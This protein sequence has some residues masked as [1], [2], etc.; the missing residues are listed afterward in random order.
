[1]TIIIIISAMSMQLYKKVYNLLIILLQQQSNNYDCWANKQ[2]KTKQN[3]TFTNNLIIITIIAIINKSQIMLQQ[4]KYT[5]KYKTCLTS[6]YDSK[7][8]FKCWASKT[9]QQNKNNTSI[10]KYQWLNI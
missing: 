10:V 3:T 1:M 7:T 4:F 2:I 9:K 6:T 8:I 5:S